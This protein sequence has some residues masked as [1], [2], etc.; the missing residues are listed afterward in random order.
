MPYAGVAEEQLVTYVF[1]CL[2]A[3]GFRWGPA[4]IEVKQTARGPVLVE[5][6]VGRFNGVR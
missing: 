4:H 1:R 6:N 5:V 3:L 2:D